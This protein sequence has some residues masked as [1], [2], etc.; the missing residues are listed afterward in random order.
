MSNHCNYDKNPSQQMYQ[1]LKQ[2]SV[3]DDQKD[4]DVHQWSIKANHL[5]LRSKT[6]CFYV[7]CIKVLYKL[8]DYIYV[9]YYN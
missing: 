7:I 1:W 4:T 2:I 9:H 3:I 8:A 5:G 6:K